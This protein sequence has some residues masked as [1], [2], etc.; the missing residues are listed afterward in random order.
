MAK[1]Y[2]IRIIKPMEIIEVNVG[3]TFNI[4]EITEYK[5]WKAPYMIYSYKYLKANSG[6]WDSKLILKDLGNGNFRYDSETGDITNE[7]IVSVLI[8]ESNDMQRV[9]NNY[10]P[11]IINNT[12]NIEN[13]WKTYYK[14]N[15]KQVNYKIIDS[16][17][18]MY[19]SD[20]DDGFIYPIEDISN[21]PYFFII[22][23][24]EYEYCSNSIKFDVNKKYDHSI[25]EIIQKPL[26]FDGEYLKEKLSSV[27]IVP[28]ENGSFL[29][30]ANL[31]IQNWYGNVDYSVY[32]DGKYIETKQIKEYF[33]NWGA[34]FSILHIPEIRIPKNSKN[35]EFRANNR[36][37][38]GSIH[39][40]FYSSS[41]S[42]ISTN[43]VK[44]KIIYIDY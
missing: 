36:P 19:W 24:M 1:W 38:E 26:E 23:D 27:E 29:A 10:I 15:T 44:F 14:L 30:S 4:F 2:D 12:K 6:F 40:G 42:N 20:E 37:G 32:I 33:N 34:S 5:K 43:N 13:N 31:C 7:S 8:M 41:Y 11:N 21:K 35:I 16:E 22:E 39:V 17:K 18:D 25:I 9:Y 28:I 3:Q